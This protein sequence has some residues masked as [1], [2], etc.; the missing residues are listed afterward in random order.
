MNAPASASTTR[1]DGFFVPHDI[2]APIPG[3]AS[4]PL[5]GLTVAVKDMYDIAGTRTGAGSPTWLETHAPARVNAPIID[6]LLSAGA[7][8]IGKTICEELFFSVTG[9]NAHYGTPANVRA[10]GR[11]PGGSSSG[12]A[13][14]TAAGACD[15]ALGSDTGGSV[16]IPA[17]FC[18]LY[19]IRPTHGRVDLAGAVPM[20]PSFDVAGWFAAAPGVFRRVGEVL[21]GGA[22]IDAKL[23]TLLLA[24]DAFAEADTAVANVAMEVLSRAMNGSVLPQVCDVQVVTDRCEAW[25][26][27]FRVVQGF[28]TWQ[29]FGAFVTS[30]KPQL[31]PG[32]KE[33]IAY[34]S[35]VT[36]AQA[37]A[38]RAT[39]A[40]ART[41]LR[42][43]VPP[44][45]VMALP[46]SP[47][48]APRVDMAADALEAL[49]VRVQRLTCM[50]VL[51]GLPQVTIPA[52]IV[53]GCPAGLSLI[54]WA[55]G[56]E[57]LLELA[58]ALARFCGVVRP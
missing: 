43:L 29:S 23:S 41:R 20:A 33:R 1:H 45:T 2:A 18:G 51:S 26:E 46:T 31:G 5:A 25:R 13:G 8:I 58:C 53:D 27:A 56:D 17:S 22:R 14:A 38:A 7:T 55:G 39:V 21:L 47:C 28:E 12:S 16:R 54:G 32:I 3:A 52:G 37:E 4:G 48:I 40:A 6:K 30:A 44:G 9:I 11:M 24:T 50:S 15:F 42:G 35:T 10:A 36:A 34:A 49:R 57:A 19:G